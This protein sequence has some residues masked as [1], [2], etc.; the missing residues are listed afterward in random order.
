MTI[1]AK[2]IAPGGVFLLT[3]VFGF[4]ARRSWIAPLAVA[5]ASVGALLV[6]TFAQP[7]IAVRGLLDGALLAGVWAAW[8]TAAARP[9]AATP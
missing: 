4:I 7:P 8:R 5:V 6:F 1:A 9:V 2:F 3:L